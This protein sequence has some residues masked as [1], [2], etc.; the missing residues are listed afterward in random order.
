MLE[1]WEDG[2][3]LVLVSKGGDK[4]THRIAI[5]QV[6]EEVEFI[7]DSDWTAGDVDLLD[8]D[9]SRSRSARMFL[10]CGRGPFRYVL[11][12][13]VPVVDVSVVVEIFGFVYSRE[14][15]YEPIS[16]MVP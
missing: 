4:W 2:N 5:P 15:A 10:A 8:S 16:I 1:V 6:V 12:F 14:C 7:E 3:N 9:I 11:V 13:D